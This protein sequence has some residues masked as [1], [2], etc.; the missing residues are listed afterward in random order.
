[1]QSGN[2]GGD[3]MSALEPG[4]YR[5]CDP[6][7]GAECPRFGTGT[8]TVGGTG[9]TV[10]ETVDAVTGATWTTRNMIMEDLFYQDLEAHAD[11]MPSYRPPGT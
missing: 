2:T 5:K 9:D 6:C 10:Q 7:R 4:C 3:K 8:S 1:M 11:Q